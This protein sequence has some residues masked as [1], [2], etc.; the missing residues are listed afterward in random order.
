M[1]QRVVITG[2]GV[3][4]PVGSTVDTFWDSLIHG[5]S[6]VGLITHFDTKDFLVKIG[7]QVQGFDVA[8]VVDPKEAKRMDRF[9]QYAMGAAVEAVA[10][11]GLDQTPSVDKTRV[12]V[13]VGCGIGGLS[14]IEAN[15]GVLQSRGPSRVSPF[16]VPMSIID[17]ASGMVSIRYGFMGPNYGV[18]SACSSAGHAFI[19]AVN[20]IRLGKVDAMVCGGTESCLTPTGVAGFTSAQA[21]STSFA[22]EPHR[23]SRPFDKNR[24]GFVM[25]EGAGMLVLES[26][27]HAQKRG[28]TIFAE[29]SGY[30][31][32]GDAYHITAPHP[33]GTGSILAFREAL[34]DSGINPEDVDYINAHGTSTPLNDKTET[35][36]FKEV[37]GSHAYK[38]SVSSTKS[39]TG[40]MIGAAAAVEAVAT[41]LA[42]R[43]GIVPPTINFETPDPEC[44][45]DVTPNV[46]KERSIRYALKNSL[47]FGGHNAAIVFKRWEG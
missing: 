23:A 5:R 39:M 42:I 40:H 13:V 8:K 11:S 27:E 46:A 47:G 15:H 16:F 18:V 14:T 7:G 37:L 20:L 3:V 30:G 29:I 1:S 21:L 4:S 34:R 24:D 31:M 2:M 41:I 25:G 19:D 44:D 9:L 26:L 22:T 43:T 45:L 28:A 10:Q 38:V 6:G 12:G 33:E 32:T 35:K 17:M 36:V